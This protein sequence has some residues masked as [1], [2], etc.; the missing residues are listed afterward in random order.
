MAL[1]PKPGVW[2]RDFAALNAKY[3]RLARRLSVIA[4]SPKTDSMAAWRCLGLDR[5]LGTAVAAMPAKGIGLLA[6]MPSIVFR[7]RSLELA[8]KL[9]RC[10]EERTDDRPQRW[11][12]LA[13]EEELPA[14]VVELAWDYWRTVRECVRHD[15]VL[16]ITL[17]QVPPALA[18]TIVELDNAE[19]DM[20]AESAAAFFVPRNATLATRMVS[21]VAANAP[22]IAVARMHVGMLCAPSYLEEEPA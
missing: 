12:A 14:G 6:A 8:L 9:A 19:I 21:L 1:F 16:G 3:W 11:L 13:G 5:M 7:P 4:D 2:E 10:L 20:L 18:D 17:C 22:A 15:R